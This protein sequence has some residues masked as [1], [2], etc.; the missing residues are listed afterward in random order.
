MENTLKNKS[1]FFLQYAGQ[2]VLFNEELVNHTADP[3]GIMLSRE[4]TEE[5][6]IVLKKMQDIT[7]EDNRHMQGLLKNNQN[8]FE[9]F[10]YKTPEIA[11]IFGTD[12]LRS[13]GYAIPWNG[14]KVHQL[15][16]YGWIKFK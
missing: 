11:Y 15:E 6:Y 4:I 1:K 2:F 8:S 14:L 5:D 13:K 16:E 10:F 7:E 3:L 12:F 9:E